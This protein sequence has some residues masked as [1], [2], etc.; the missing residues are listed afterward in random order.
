[1]V[2]WHMMGKWARIFS[3]Q[4]NIATEN[5]ICIK[6]VLTPEEIKKDRKKT[7]RKS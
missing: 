5:C 3:I 4:S 1:M 2:K 7:N 6:T